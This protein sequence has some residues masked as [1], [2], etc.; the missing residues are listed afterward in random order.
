VR[1]IGTLI[2]DERHAKNGFA[3]DANKTHPLA[4][5]SSTATKEMEMTTTIK[6]EDIARTQRR[7]VLPRVLPIAVG[8]ALALASA[9]AYAQTQ[10]SVACAGPQKAAEGE[11]GPGALPQKAA[12]GEGGPGALPQ[13]AAEGEGG[14]GA[15]PQKAAD[16]DGG[17]GAL[18]QK[19]AEGEG[20]ALAQKAAAAKPCKA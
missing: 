17:P 1:P 6:I 20:A 8:L 10:P 19:A 18:P 12:E 14:P 11:G 5:N 9:T 4:V 13:K 7:R 16:G 3:T 2:E 15:L